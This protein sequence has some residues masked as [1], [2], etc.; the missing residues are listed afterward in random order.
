[1]LLAAPDL[2]FGADRPGLGPI[3][4]DQ[5][6]DF[7]LG[8][9]LAGGHRRQPTRPNRSD[10]GT[11]LG[12]GRHTNGPRLIEL[13]GRPATAPVKVIRRGGKA[14]R[15]RGCSC[16]RAVRGRERRNGSS[17]S[18]Q[19]GEVRWQTCARSRNPAEADSEARRTP[20]R[21]RRHASQAH[22]IP[23]S[24]PSRRGARPDW[25]GVRVWRG[26][27][28]ARDNRDRGIRACA[29]TTRSRT[30]QSATG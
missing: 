11:D 12:S 16:E 13:N 2:R 5:L 7:A 27:D 22:T 1:M 29:P 18:G 14:G 4:H 24:P 9:V 25:D 19:E 6:H 21:P 8:S 3:A 30:S 17:W 26:R 28:G 20:L 15:V 10:P 23:A